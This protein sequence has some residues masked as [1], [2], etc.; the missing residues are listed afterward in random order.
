MLC[1]KQK[2]RSLNS[3]HIPVHVMDEKRRLHGF[4]VEGDLSPCNCSRWNAK[5]VFKR[6]GLIPETVLNDKLGATFSLC[7]DSLRWLNS[8]VCFCDPG[9]IFELGRFSFHYYD[10]VFKNISSLRMFQC[11]I[12]VLFDKYYGYLFFLIDKF[13]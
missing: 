7:Y 11:H 4:F 6:G 5:S 8:K 13:Y 12:S 1:F 9:I 2:F 10:A 3:E